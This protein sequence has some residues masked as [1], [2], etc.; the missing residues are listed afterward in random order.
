MYRK[1]MIVLLMNAAG[2]SST[3][4]LSPEGSHRE[5]LMLLYNSSPV[6][7]G[8]EGFNSVGDGLSTPDVVQLNVIPFYDSGDLPS[9]NLVT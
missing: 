3:N 1:Y 6:W 4:L 2:T 5:R 8:E 9:R 7:T